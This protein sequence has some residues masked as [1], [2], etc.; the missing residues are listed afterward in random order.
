M[1]SARPF[2]YLDNFQQ[3]LDWLAQR[4]ADLLDLRE[5][6][7][8][9]A[10]PGLP[11]PSRALLVRMMM[12][13]GELFRT[14][15]LDYPEI[16]CPLEAA[17]GLP[18]DWVERDAALTLEQFFSL[19]TKPELVRA[20][21]LTGAQRVAR[22]TDLLAQLAADPAWDQARVL[23]QWCRQGDELALRL[24]VQDL[25]D[26]LRLMFF[27][28]LRQDW[29]EFVLADLGRFRYERVALSP[30]ARGFRQRSD[31]DHYLR[32]HACSEA[33]EAGEDAADVMAALTVVAPAEGHDNPWLQ[34]RYERLLFKLG[35]H[36]EKQGHW[37]QAHAVYARCP[38][39][40]AR[41][42][43][44]RVL[45]KQGRFAQAYA[46]FQ[47]AQ[48]APESEAERQ[49]LQRIGPRL[50]RQLGYPPMVR[51]RTLPPQRLDLVLAMQAG[52]G[53]EAAVRAHLQTLDAPVFY[54][55]NT[56]ATALFGLLCWDAIFAAI[57]G[58][59]FHP[60]QRAPAD[61]HSADFHAR[62]REAFAHCLAL[63]D[64][65]RHREAILA[66]YEDKQGVL[67][68]FVSWGAIS[69]ELLVLA[70]DCIPAWHLKHWCLR[71]LEDVR[72]N[73]SGFPDLIQFW[74]QQRRYRM[75]E[76]KGPGDR[77]Q[78][79]QQRWLAFCAQH[80]M[81]VAVCYLQWQQQ[82]A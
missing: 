39:P 67:S 82:A 70:L 42:R 44:M 72:E 14:G 29:S 34:S 45:E 1:P 22:K 16:G 2:Y 47:A 25:C 57:P 74:P 66:A 32:L 38:Y 49:H 20:F 65:E 75:I 8:I 21:A 41:G 37:P 56:L 31:V 10:F 51:V 13:K 15:R 79:N 59:F 55:E 19:S 68:P 76:V 50:T 40:G 54:V 58:A 81:P 80:Q 23:R 64:Q 5:R 30:E 61:L 63:L 11:L 6:Q 27:G 12:R 36:L 17:K 3:V 24:R 35:Q 28:N 77:L 60:F 73:R 69:R 62:R 7:F 48:A 9:A 33:L 78:D 4:C 26:R 71:I 53:V 18:E 52:Q 43:A 46:L